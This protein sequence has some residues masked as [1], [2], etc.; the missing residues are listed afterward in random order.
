MLHKLLAPRRVGVCGSS[1]NLRPDAIP[2]CKAVGRAL[3]KNENIVIVSGGTKR[4]RDGQNDAAEDDLAADWHIVNTA[5]Q[6]I[7]ARSGDEAVIQRIETF[8]IDDNSASAEQFRIGTQKHP[9]GKTSEAR[10][11]SFVKSLDGLLA[12]GGRMGTS[13]ELALAME[14][15][16]RVLPVPLFP[17]KAREFWRSYEKDL[18]R[19]LRIDLETA[20]RWWA[21]GLADLAETRQI[22]VDEAERLGVEMVAVLLKALPRRCFVI[23]PFSDEYISLYDFVIAPA[24]LNFGD[25]PIRLDRTAIPGDAGDQIHEGISSCDY[26]IAVLDDLRPNVLY[27]LGLAHAYGKPTILMN[28]AGTLGDKALAPFDLSLKQRLEYRCVEASLVDQLKIRITN[29]P[30]ARHS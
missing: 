7:R 28:R 21:S 13:Q 3:A 14:L 19:M 10:R 4:R 5:E 6:E 22:A 27:E 23:M 18:I 15:G 24:V 29:L 8:V 1:K 26:V 11:F 16:H 9:R 30:A 12:I 25:D 17:G 2:F 20:N